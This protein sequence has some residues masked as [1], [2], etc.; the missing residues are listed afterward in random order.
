MKPCL[1]LYVP[2]IH[3]GYRQLF[4]TYEKKTAGLYVLGTSLISE[5]GYLEREIRALPPN[6]VCD[7]LR[8]T[9]Q[10]PFIKVL[11]RRHIRTLRDTYI[12]TADE[13]ITRRIAKRYFRRS[14]VQ[15]VKSFL[16]WDEGFVDTKTPT[17]YDRISRLKNDRLLMQIARSEAEKS[18]DWWRHVGAIIPLRNK[19]LAAHNEHVPSEYAQYAHGDIRDFIPAGTKSDICSAIHAEKNLVAQAARDGT[20][21]LGRSLYVTTF[22]CSDCARVIAYAGIKKCFFGGGHASFDGVG[23]LKAY[24]VELIF[25][26]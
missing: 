4:R 2:V 22:P 20:S 12:I 23:V 7:I 11:G 3:D 17:T 24:G 26:K 14:R 19:L 1:V 5:H 18:S 16:R 13:Q 15:Y 8:A 21:L 25:V 6:D 10:F 9:T